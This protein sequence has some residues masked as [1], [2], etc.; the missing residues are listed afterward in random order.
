[1]HVWHNF[2]WSPYTMGRG[3]KRGLNSRGAPGGATGDPTLRRN[4]QAAWESCIA[5]SPAGS[6]PTSFA[7]MEHLIAHHSNYRRL[8]QACRCVYCHLHDLTLFAD[9]RNRSSVL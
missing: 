4:V 2:A 8:K 3:S 9:H 5:T 7:I 1:M 6:M